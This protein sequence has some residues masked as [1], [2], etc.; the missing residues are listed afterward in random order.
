MSDPVR[1]FFIF[2]ILLL[3]STGCSVKVSGEKSFDQGGGGDKD[4]V[5]EALPVEI[6]Q[7]GIGEIRSVLKFTTALEAERSVDVLAEASRRVV[8][9]SVEEGDVVKANQL[10]ARLE[11]GVQRSALEKAETSLEQSRREYERQKSLWDQKLISEQVFIDA[12]YNFDQAKLAASDARR[13]L[14]YTRV[15]APISGTLTERMISLG[16]FVSLNQK[17]FH[18]TDFSSIV[19]RIYVPEQDLSS[20]SVGTPSEIR[21]PALGDGTIEGHILRI[22]PVVDPATGTI[23]VT[24]A[25]PRGSGLRPGMYVEVDLVTAIHSEAL[26]IPKRAVVYDNEQTFVF[27]LK[28]GRRVE[29]VAVVPRIQDSESIE[30]ED[31]F[32]VGDEIVVAGQSGLKDGALVRLPGDPKPTATPAGKSRTS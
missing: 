19:A 20:I 13:E 3:M 31:G 24:V 2:F 10:L 30:P 26:L 4:R 22:S 32:E 29:R 27:R 18:I 16:D 6:A 7:V 23:K 8:E 28:E 21:A 1:D 14:E 11:D 25:I 12:Q 9:L 17:L 15:R 5:E